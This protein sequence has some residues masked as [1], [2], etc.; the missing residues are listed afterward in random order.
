MNALLLDLNP[1]FFKREIQCLKESPM[2]CMGLLAGRSPGN[3]YARLGL[4]AE[5]WTVTLFAGLSRQRI[6]ARL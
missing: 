5:R 1:V 2:S 6:E 3:G 4:A